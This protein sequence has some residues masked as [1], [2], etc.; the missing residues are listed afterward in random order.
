M[1]FDTNTPSWEKNTIFPALFKI[2]QTPEAVN[3]LARPRLH[4]EIMYMYEKSP[5]PINQTSV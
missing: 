4:L 3:V 2:H 5:T 1:D